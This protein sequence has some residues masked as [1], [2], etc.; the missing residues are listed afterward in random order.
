MYRPRVPCLR[1]VLSPEWFEGQIISIG[2]GME[3]VPPSW[4]SIAINEAAGNCVEDM[5]T[6]TSRDRCLDFDMAGV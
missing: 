3:E 6:A 2:I 1:K 4:Q 5:S